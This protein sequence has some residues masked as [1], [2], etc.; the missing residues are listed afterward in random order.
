MTVRYFVLTTLLILIA[1]LC[2]SQDVIEWSEDSKIELSDFGSATTKIG[3]T[4]MIS[5]QDGSI[6]AFSFAMTRG[7]FMLTKNF[8]SK[9][10]CEF[11]RKIASIVAPDSTAARSLLSLVRYNFDLSELY[12]RKFRKELY[13]NKG[14]FSNISF[15]QPI[16]DANQK[17]YSERQTRV[18]TETEFGQKSER[19]AELHN[20]VMKEIHELADFCKTCKP[21]KKK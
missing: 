17:E 8:N 18:A 5:F 16:Y 6:I 7:E 13:E 12:A 2:F 11:R 15:F 4:R 3:D 21:A 19:L 9:V 14:A 1:R 20:E 10:R